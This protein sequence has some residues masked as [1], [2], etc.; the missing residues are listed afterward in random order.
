MKYLIYLSDRWGVDTYNILICNTQEQSDS[1]IE[2]YDKLK[3]R[4]NNMSEVDVQQRKE[5]LPKLANDL[6]ILNVELGGYLK[7]DWSM[8]AE[9]VSCIELE[10]I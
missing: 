5:E 8:Y 2:R 1:L 7:D 6:Q 10:S 9:E 3:N 4:F